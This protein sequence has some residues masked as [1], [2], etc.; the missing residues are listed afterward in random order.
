MTDPWMPADTELRLGSRGGKVALLQSELNKRRPSYRHRDL[1]VDAIFGPK[2]ER[3]VKR[4]QKRKGLK[5]DGLAGPLTLAALG[6]ELLDEKLK[7]VPAPPDVPAP[8]PKPDSDL[9]GSYI[10]EPDKS[11]PRSL[12]IAL[13]ALVF[14]LL[15][16]LVVLT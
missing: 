12:W 5:V 14:A 2:T 11:E 3:A 6:F 1:R 13:G 8:E 4:F 15:T 16:A 7:P 10:S 9:D